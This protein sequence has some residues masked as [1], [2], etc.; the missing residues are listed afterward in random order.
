MQIYSMPIKKLTQERY[1][2]LKNTHT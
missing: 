2:S 1:S